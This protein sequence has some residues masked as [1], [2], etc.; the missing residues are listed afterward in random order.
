MGR[1][2]GDTVSFS[3]LVFDN[4]HIIIAL[5]YIIIG[6]IYLGFLVNPDTEK[7]EKEKEKISFKNG[8]YIAL[9]VFYVLIG[10]IYLVIQIKH[11]SIFSHHVEEYLKKYNKIY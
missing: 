7:V 5:L 9:C 4:N 1:R 8:L 6:G 10:I 3:K 2:F 11:T